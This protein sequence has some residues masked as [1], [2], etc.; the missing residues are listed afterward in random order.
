M[1][2]LDLNSYAALA[3]IIGTI[4]TGGV[5]I[6]RKLFLKKRAESS[7]AEIQFNGGGT[8]IVAR[9]GSNVAIHGSITN[10][11]LGPRNA[12]PASLAKPIIKIEQTG[13]SNGGSPHRTVFSFQLTNMGGDFFTLNVYHGTEIVLCA[14]QLSRG[15]SGK[16][17]LDLPMRPTRI[18]IVSMGFDANGDEVS[19]SCSGIL[20]DTSSSR[21]E[22]KDD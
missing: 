21:Y 2:T 9:E 1:S 3:T 8:Q 4:C 18:E 14:P 13:F 15:S 16:F 20:S 7:G 17:E 10:N 19:I 6:L 5:F 11:P 12:T 22:F